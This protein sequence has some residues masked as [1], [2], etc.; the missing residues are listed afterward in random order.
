MLLGGLAE[1]VSLGLVVPFLATMAAPA[2]IL[3]YEFTQIIYFHI[4]NTWNHLGIEIKQLQ[5]DPQY[6]LLFLACSFIVVALFTG[7]VRLA[8]VWASVRFA[9]ALGTDLGFEAYRR[10]LYQPYSVHVSR[11]SSILISSFT[12]KI[13]ILTI[14]EV[15]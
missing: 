3:D 5:P 11:N 4:T 6:L 8:L 7:G 12:S 13:S 15:S 9:G 2:K 14:T 1:A 10:T